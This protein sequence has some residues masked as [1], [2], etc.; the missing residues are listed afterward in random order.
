MKQS[1]LGYGKKTGVNVQFI[2]PTMGSENEEFAV[3]VAGRDLQ[4]LLNG[5][6]QFHMRV[7]L[8]PQRMK[9]S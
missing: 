9:V 6:G 7:V 3:L 5:N 2:H 1:G 4:I 8:Q